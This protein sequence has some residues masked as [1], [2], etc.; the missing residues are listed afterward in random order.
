MF[1]VSIIIN[2]P[3]NLAEITHSS[4]F[5]K[6]LVYVFSHCKNKKISDLLNDNVSKILRRELRA[7]F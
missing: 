6:S 1:H 4:F 2:S 7:T 5:K 3:F